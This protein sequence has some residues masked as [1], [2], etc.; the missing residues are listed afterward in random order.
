MKKWYYLILFLVAFTGCASKPEVITSKADRPTAKTPP[1]LFG[2]NTQP[3][4]IP[5]GMN[6]GTEPTSTNDANEA[7]EE[8]TIYFGYNMSNIKISAKIILKKHANYLLENHN[9][10]VR[11]EGHADERG[12]TEYNLALGEQRSETAKKILMN[13][14]VSGNQIE[15]L[16]YGEERP[17]LF[18]HGEESWQL[19]RRVELVYD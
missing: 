17:I 19:N 5:T 14:G 12:S 18:G 15:S 2:Q 11:L 13:L 6:I 4:N 16:S 3:T 1:P 9:I 10:T 7:P 8:K